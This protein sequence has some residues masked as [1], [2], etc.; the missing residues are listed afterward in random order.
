MRAIAVA[1]G[2]H[3]VEF[4]YRPGSFRLGLLLALAGLLVLAARAFASIRHRRTL[5]R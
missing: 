5:A 2:T 1:V 3:T 4:R